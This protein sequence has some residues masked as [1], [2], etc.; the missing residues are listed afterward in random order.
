MTILTTKGSSPSTVTSDKGRAGRQSSG[1]TSQPRR[2][3]GPAVGPRLGEGRMRPGGT[4]G[5]GER[6]GPSR[7][8]TSPTS[9]ITTAIATASRNGGKFEP[10]KVLLKVSL[11]HPSLKYIY[12]TIYQSWPIT[13]QLRIP[14]P[15]LLAN[16][17]YHSYTNWILMF[18]RSRSRSNCCQHQVSA[19]CDCGAG[20]HHAGGGFSRSGK[21]S[22]STRSTQWEVYR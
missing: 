13:I 11:C 12:N 3:G 4:R 10:L 1:A 16:S 20:D 5:E 19:Q 14:I 6:A 8:D 18:S 9:A 17:V 15:I 21:S 22:Q 7:R 2:Q